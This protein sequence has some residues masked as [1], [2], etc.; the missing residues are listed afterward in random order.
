M[1]DRESLWYW[2]EQKGQTGNKGVVIKMVYTSFKWTRW[3]I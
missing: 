2:M 3:N 1:A